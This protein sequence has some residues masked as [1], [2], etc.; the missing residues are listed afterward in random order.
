MDEYIGVEVFFW[1]YCISI[2]LV[3]IRRM[4]LKLDSLGTLFCEIQ[5]KTRD[6]VSF[7]VVYRPTGANMDLSLSFRN[8]LNKISRTRFSSVILAGDFNFPNIDW[9]SLTNIEWSSYFRLTSVQLWMT[10]FCLKAILLLLGLLMAQPIFWTWY[11]QLLQDW[12]RIFK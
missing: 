6:S 8:C 3:S 9:H 11:W 5:Q 2:N 12:Y 1:Q 7:G 10:I 4:D